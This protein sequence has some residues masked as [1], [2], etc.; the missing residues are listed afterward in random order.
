VKRLLINRGFDDELLE[1]VIDFL[2]SIGPDEPYEIYLNSSGGL[3]VIAQCLKELLDGD[4]RATLVGYS[5]VSS[6]ALFLLLTVKCKKRIVSGTIGVFHL[7]YIKNQELNMDLSPRDIHES[8]SSYLGSDLT[9]EATK[10]MKGYLTKKQFKGVKRYKDIW[11][12]H[13]Q[14]EEILKKSQKKV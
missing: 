5:E 4:E 8:F 1:I 6:A 9:Y 12:S 10:I 2:S 3:E 11:L 13:K 14:I 7:P